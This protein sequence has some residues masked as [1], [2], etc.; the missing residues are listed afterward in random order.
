MS[1]DESLEFL[2]AK[3]G[4]WGERVTIAVKPVIHV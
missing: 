3:F 2:E 4:D 1:L